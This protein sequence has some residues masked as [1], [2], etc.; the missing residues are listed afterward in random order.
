M[1]G[2]RVWDSY[3]GCQ[4][5]KKS[6][7]IE[8]NNLPKAC[9]DDCK[10][11]YNIQPLG[12]VMSQSYHN[13]YPNKS[14]LLEGIG[15]QIKPAIDLKSPDSLKNSNPIN[16]FPFKCHP[17][18]FRIQSRNSACM[19]HNYLF[20]FFNFPLLNHINDCCKAFSSVT[21]IK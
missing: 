16:Q 20:P 11:L 6:R 5:K 15:R 17:M 2:G 8:I 12:T 4:V 18:M 19:D 10:V 14:P 13:P 7:L 9:V 1:R 21:G 3:P